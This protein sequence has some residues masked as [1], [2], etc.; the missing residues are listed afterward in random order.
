MKKL[1]WLF[2]MFLSFAFVACDDDDDE[3]DLDVT[4]PTINIMSP[5]A[6]ATYSAGDVVPLRAEIEDNLGLDE[7]VVS[8]TD[9]SGTNREIEDDKIRDF[10]NDNTNKE[11]DLDIN[12]DENASAGA[13]MIIVEAT[14]E[15]G[16]TADESVTISVM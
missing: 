4:A 16:N 9:P 2:L 5:T 3:V 14:D 12:L 8:V 11:L 15:Q 7:V 13:Y 10:L 1:N 6:N